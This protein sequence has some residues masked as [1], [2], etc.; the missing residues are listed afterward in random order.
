MAFLE[1][2][3]VKGLGFRDP[4]NNFLFFPRFGLVL[5]VWGARILTQS[6]EKLLHGRAWEG[7]AHGTSEP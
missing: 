6:P 1:G 7:L 5:G 4:A 2:F 3:R